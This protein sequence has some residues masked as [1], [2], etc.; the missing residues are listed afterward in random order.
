MEARSKAWTAYYFPQ[1]SRVDRADNY[2]KKQMRVDESDGGFRI[3]YYLNNAEVC[4][5]VFVMAYRLGYRRS[6]KS[7]VAPM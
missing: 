4:R 5:N 7:L 1:P 6:A 3:H 2:I